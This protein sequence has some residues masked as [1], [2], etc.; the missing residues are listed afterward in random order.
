MKKILLASAVF[1][2]VS[3]V[4]AQEFVAAWD[5]ASFTAGGTSLDTNFDFV[6]D[7]SDFIS[8]D[9][10]GSG[11]FS[12]SGASPDFS[13]F[14]SSS[15]LSSNTADIVADNFGLTQ[16][17]GGNGW[18][19][20]ATDAAGLVLT[21]SGLDFSGLFGATLNF[22]ALI[23]NFDNTDGAIVLG[24]GLSETINLSGTDTAYN[25]IDISALDGV[26]NAS[27]TMTFT[28]I[29]GAETVRLDN[30]QIVSAVPE[31]SSFAA[32]FGALALGFTAIRRR[33]A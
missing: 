21:F 24:G 6:E 33:R 8:A 26:A 30:V 7:S 22:A 13:G 4:S 1:A 25:G 32:I 16:L 9:Y 14:F 17:G 29:T 5:F 19:T 12:W 20:A 11:L 23:T 31:P 10:A 2:A 27:F 18:T 28:G 3:T 15:N